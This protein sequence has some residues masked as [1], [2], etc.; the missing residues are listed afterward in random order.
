MS[1]QHLP[2]VDGWTCHHTEEDQSTCF[3][4]HDESNRSTWE[5][6]DTLDDIP[7][8]WQILADGEGDAYYVHVE[9]NKT[10]WTLAEIEEQSIGQT[11]GHSLNGVLNTEKEKKEPPS[12][13][14]TDSTI[15]PP[16]PSPHTPS[17]DITIS[18]PNTASV[19]D[20]APTTSDATTIQPLPNTASVTDDAPT[21]SDA[22]T[23][24]PVEN[25]KNG[26]RK[27]SSGG[28]LRRLSEKRNRVAAAP[29][30]KEFKSVP[31]QIEVVS[32]NVGNQQPEEKELERL[33]CPWRYHGNNE[34]NEPDVIVVGTQECKYKQQKHTMDAKA[35]HKKIEEQKERE[36]VNA[37]H[38]EVD[39][40]HSHWMN[41]LTMVVG[42]K[43]HIVSKEHLLEMR[44]VVFAK[45]NVFNKVV[46][47]SHKHKATGIAH[48][49][50][51]KGGLVSSIKFGGTIMT[52]VSCHLAAH[53]KH[54]NRRHQDVVDIL[55]S[56]RIGNHRLDVTAQSNHVI[57]LGD[58]NFR[59]DLTD[60]IDGK[61]TNHMEHGE[62]FRE[63]SKLVR[64]S[65][66]SKL[67]QHDQLRRGMYFFILFM[68][69]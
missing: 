1:E 62:H 28:R 42:S 59:I 52:F 60:S 66:W 65:E 41:L 68:I 43:Y 54:L 38:G 11:G 50:G 15:S 5:Y 19:T 23:I 9:T 58:L 17:T 63:V 26:R 35:M 3:Y 49:Y 25:P 61:A 69:L 21:T 18:L 14:T 31:I 6:K 55:K 36:H 16:I 4:Y 30:L 13:I 12:I 29:S 37:E 34:S 20:D 47:V 2:L 22:T 24:Q 7:Q 67:Y 33:V 8:G 56:A 10:V 45:S 64:N 44:L 48:I 51:N 32:W 53:S 27:N 46:G 57:W 39:S 40:G